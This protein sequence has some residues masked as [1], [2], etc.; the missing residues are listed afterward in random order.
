MSKTVEPP[1]PK[2]S[3]T[4]V[5]TGIL[6]AG[7]LTLQTRG[8]LEKAERVYY[9]V[10]DP[11]TERFILTLAPAAQSLGPLYL[12]GEDRSAIYDT[13]AERIVAPVRQGQRVAAAFYGH[14]GVCAAAG[15]R[16]IR[17]A[18]EEG[19][20]ARMLPAISAEDCLVADLGLDPLADGLH[21]FEATRFLLAGR[22]PDITVPLVLWQIGAIG[23]DTVGSGEL[24]HRQNLAILAEV[25]LRTYPEDHE[26]TIY[27]ASALAV[28][29]P[30]LEK[31]P[32]G[33][34]ANAAVTTLSTLVIPALEDPSIHGA[35]RVRLGLGEP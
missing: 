14:P 28:R 33:E 24:W 27:E 6:A 31:L 3:L 20:E 32:L 16:A 11:I 34:L 12:E 30:R 2:G 10:V 22:E 7:H 8:V 25:L 35:M 1:Q 5:G 26:V 18:R 9:A 17:L 15:H 29:P 23:V 19:L 21:T 13:M 4:V